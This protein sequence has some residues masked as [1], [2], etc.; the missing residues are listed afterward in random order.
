MQSIA[1]GAG[2]ASGHMPRVIPARLCAIRPP[3]WQILPIAVLAAVGL[4]ACAGQGA[5]GADRTAAPS[6]SSATTGTTDVLRTPSARRRSTRPVAAL[7]LITEPN[8]GIAPVLNAIEHARHSVELVMYEDE[9][10]RVDAALAADEHRG[11]SVRVLLNDGYHGQGSPENQGAYGYL[12][13]HN[14]PVRWTPSYFALTHQKT[15]VADG[16]AY[17]LTF[18]LTPAYYASSRDFGVVDSNPNDLSA[19]LRNFDADWSGQRS[20]APDGKDLVWSPGSEQAQLNLVESAHEWLDVYNEEMDESDIEHALEADARRGVN[21]EVTMT[22]D[23]SWDQAFAELSDAGVHVRTYAANAPLYIHAKV[24]LTS[25]R[26]FLG[27][28]N[29]SD[30]SLFDNRELGIVL[31]T[32]SIIASLHHTFGADYAGAHPFTAAPP[33]ASSNSPP[34]PSSSTAECS[35]SA[36]YSSRYH[37]YDVYVH[38]NQPARI[39]TVTDGAG[40]SANWHTDS[41][42]Y[43]DVYFDAPVGAAGETVTVRV[44][45]ATCQAGL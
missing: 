24:I 7:S 8:Q 10:P 15:L 30:G 34:V 22:A 6:P 5:S 20:A 40:R 1:G 4:S 29:F 23:P 43:A 44:G 9:D 2:C 32:A 37:D 11:V 14:V 36:S 35:A 13:S 3:R 27:S 12:Q 19:I 25:T 38:S 42:G 33:A 21:V 31:S 41:S 16:T 26:A 39:V 45:A 18:N 28:E 17:I